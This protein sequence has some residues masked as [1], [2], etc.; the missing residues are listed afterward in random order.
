MNQVSQEMLLVYPYLLSALKRLVESLEWE[1]R[2]SGMTY[3]GY[4]D[5]KNAI[6][7]AEKIRWRKEKS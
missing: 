2:R 5:A 7:K 4:D 6:W 1:E 3:A